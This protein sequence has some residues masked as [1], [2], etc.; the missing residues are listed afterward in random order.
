M[1]KNKLNLR[2]V[3][4]IAACLA[5]SI[6]FFSCD[7]EKDDDNN[8]DGVVKLVSTISWDYG[9]YVWSEKYEY[10]E[11]SRITKITTYDDGDVSRIFTLAYNNVGD[12][13]SKK[14]QQ[15]GYPDWIET[16]SKSGNKITIIDE[17]EYNY[18]IDLNAQGLPI[19]A[20]T[21]NNSNLHMI[22]LTWQNGNI[23]KV[24]QVEEGEG[25]TFSH[26]NNFTYDDKKGVF[27]NCNTPKWYFV[28]TWGLELF[29][30]DNNH[31]K[32]SGIEG[33]MGNVTYAYTYDN[34]GYPTKA[35]VVESYEDEGNDEYEI[36]F[37][38]ITKQE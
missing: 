17:G 10:D 5:V 7:K 33:G 16:Y 14:I 19:K 9:G 35:K 26:V 29:G 25:Y 36:M 20:T 24:E 15:S 23:T 37:T 3:A 31:T 38:Y 28:H 11:Q 4:A 30:T 12:L 22:T 32:I 21:E 2:K 8:Q 18:T 34:D 13:I 27:S 1:F 6:I